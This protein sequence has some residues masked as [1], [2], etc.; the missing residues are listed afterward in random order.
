M[1]SKEESKM[2]A[3]GFKERK[4]HVCRRISSKEVICL[5]MD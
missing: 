5:Q 1:D 3:D 4:Y 2:Y